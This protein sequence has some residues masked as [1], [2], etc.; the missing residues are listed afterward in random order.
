MLLFPDLVKPDGSS[1][2]MTLSVTGRRHDRLREHLLTGPDE[3]LT[4]EELVELLLGSPCTAAT[5]SAW[6][7]N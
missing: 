7:P 4:D 6:L 3:E 2:A 5:F 1:V